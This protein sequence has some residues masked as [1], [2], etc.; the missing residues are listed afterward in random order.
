MADPDTSPP[1][2]AQQQPAPTGRQIGA[3]V[4]RGVYLALVLIAVSLIAPQLFDRLLEV[5]SSAERLRTIRPEW[6]LVMIALEGVSFVFIWWLIR[7]VLPSVSWFVAATSQLTS[8]AVSRVVPG[9]AAVGGATLYRM[10]S[11]S[12]VTAAEAGGALAATSIISTAALFA[13][14]ASGGLMAL[15]GAPVPE[16]LL[17]VAIAGAVMF[18]VLVGA[19]AIAIVTTRPL[20][21]LGRVLNRSFSTIGG[22]FHKDW[23][24]EPHHLVEERDRLV[25]VI[26]N[27]WPQVTAAA[28]LNWV[29]DYLTLVAALYAIGADPRLSL[30]L[31]AYSSAAVL[32]MIPITPGGFGFV[33][34]G[35]TGLLIVSGISAQNAALATLAYRI[36]SLWVPLAS[37]IVAWFAFRHRYTVAD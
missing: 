3:Y 28:A 16:S 32:A 8:N 33:E 25:S 2:A 29:F 9:G 11:V 19:G 14:P 23:G 36:I 7:I 4:K 12:G 27:K 15:F 1:P 17:S 26:G 22:W 37:G 20:D 21:L 34:V 13:I 18:A 30:V 5:L 10:L 31:L 24:F 35:L 6:F